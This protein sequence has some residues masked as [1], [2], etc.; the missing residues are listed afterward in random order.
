MVVDVVVVAVAPSPKFQAYEAMLPYATVDLDASKLVAVPR[1]EPKTER[2]ATGAWSGVIATPVDSFP[3]VMGV[4]VVFVPVSIGVTMVLRLV[5]NAVLPS[6]VNE[7][8]AEP[9]ETGIGAAAVLVATWIGMTLPPPTVTYAVAPFGEIATSSAFMFAPSA[10]GVPAT[11]V[12]VAMGVTA[13]DRPSATY[14]VTPS[15]VIARFC[16]PPPTVMVVPTF[17]VARSIALTLPVP[18][19]G[20]TT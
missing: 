5:T 12:A 8:P 16:A 14:K 19:P 4:S 20:C 2:S 1:A 18:V 9:P 15:G 17:P 3:T 11:F 7:I 10:I 13:S 6:G